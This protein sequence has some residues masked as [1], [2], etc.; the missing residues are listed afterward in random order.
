MSGNIEVEISQEQPINKLIFTELEEEAVEELVDYEEDPRYVER[1][2]MNALEKSVE[3]RVA[4]LKESGAVN[5]PITK[6]MTTQRVDNN[7][8]MEESVEQMEAGGEI[9]LEGLTIED[10]H[11]SNNNQ[12]NVFTPV[13]V[14]KQPTVGQ[15]R[16][17]RNS[18]FNKGSVQDNAEEIKRKDNELTGEGTVPGGKRYSTFKTPGDILA[19]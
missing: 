16:S 5:I 3:I 6:S 13:K 4:K 8:E 1:M 7:K 18:K 11:G 19:K 12:Q 10:T 2:E 15:R 17:T 14:K 9:V